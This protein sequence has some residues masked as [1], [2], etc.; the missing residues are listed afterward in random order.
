MRVVVALGGNA[1]LKRGDDGTITEQR[2]AIREACDGLAMLVADGHQLVVTHGNGPQVG[3]LMLQDEALPDRLPRFPLDVHVAATQGQLGYLIQQE[4]AAA[5]RRVA[6][7]RPVVTVITQVVVDAGDPGFIRPTKPVGPY[8]SAKGVADFRARGVEIAEVPGGGH[9]RVVASPTPL[10]VVEADSVRALLDAGVVPIAAGGG[11]V[12]VVREGSGWRG[13]AAVID[14]DLTAAVLTIA[15][16]ADLLLILTDADHVV[17]GFGTDAA[18]PLARLS[19][20]EARA[21]IDSGAFPRG[22]M[23]EKVLAAA[24]VAEHGARAIIASITSPVAALAGNTGT[25]VVVDDP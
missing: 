25:E 4:L 17:R 5:L 6:H 12:P 1:I 7:A 21:G 23:G 14:K 16:G 8:L 15:V 9:R 20:S 24:I 13:V 3:R 19:T 11:G 10:E 22:S 18:E 2:I